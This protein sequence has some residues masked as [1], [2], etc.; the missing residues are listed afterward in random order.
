M[1]ERTVTHSDLE[2]A[3]TVSRAALFATIS[4]HRRRKEAGPL[5]YL[6]AP[7]ARSPRPKSLYALP[8]AGL[9]DIG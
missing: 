3:K 7:I 9:P 6:R 2:T 8:Q 1:S 4:V 5:R